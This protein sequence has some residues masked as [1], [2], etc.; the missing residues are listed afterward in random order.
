MKTAIVTLAS[1]LVALSFLQACSTNQ[2]ASMLTVPM[3]PEEHQAWVNKNLDKV[4][5]KKTFAAS[6]GMKMPYRIFLPKGYDKTK[7]YP[8]FV[9]LH[10]RGDRGT[11][12]RAKMFNSRGLFTGPQSIVSPNGQSQFESIVIIPQC[13]DKT[14]NEEWAH[15]IGNSPEQP[16]VGLGKDGSYNQHRKPSMSGAAA[17]ELIDSTIRSY[18]VDVSRV[19]LT[20]T[21]M[22]GFGA[23]EFAT[24]R[25][26]LFAVVVPMAGF[27]DTNTAEKIKDIPIW[28]FHGNEDENNPVQGSRNMSEKL[29]GLNAEIKYT[30]YPG[31]NHGQ[32]FVEAWKN[33]EILP[34]M[35]SKVK[36]KNKK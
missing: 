32:S 18:A 36:R 35:F 7:Q 25:P 33:T 14:P 21:S 3:L 31:L 17:L 30:E 12:N 26:D 4:L 6:N 27:S 16:F 22:G 8:L 20:G 11:D 5:E 2:Q 1:F 24:R 10:G 15:W 13:S 23:W 34:W 28:V 9:F 29:K 19:Y